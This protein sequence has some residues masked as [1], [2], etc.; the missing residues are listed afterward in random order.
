VVY[1]SV[2]LTTFD[3]SLNCLRPR[4]L[5]VLYGQSS[6][7]VP[8]FAIQTLN[9]KGSLFL[10]RPSL[11]AYTTTREELLW[12]ASEVFDWIKADELIIRM[13]KQFPLAE[14]ATAQRYLE[15]RESKGKVVLVI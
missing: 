13:D 4:G 5:M 9:S 15:G 3:K 10:T 7:V 6:G 11:G 1:D 2:G 12:R 8:P 14:A